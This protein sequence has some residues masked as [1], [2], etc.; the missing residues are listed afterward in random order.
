MPPISQMKCEVPCNIIKAHV[1]P[2][3]HFLSSGPTLSANKRGTF[4][5]PQ[6]IRG[7]QFE[8][9]KKRMQKQWERSILWHKRYSKEKNSSDSGV[10][11]VP[12]QEHHNANNYINNILEILSK[13][14]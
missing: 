13:T 10:L 8:A 11:V 5:S 2:T 3:E 4:V 6:Q 12:L 9:G 7:G 14:T 1:L